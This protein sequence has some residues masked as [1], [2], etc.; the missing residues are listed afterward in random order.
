MQGFVGFA[1]FDELLGKT[2][3]GEQPVFARSAIGSQDGPGLQRA[4]NRF[5]G[6][7]FRLFAFAD[8][9]CAVDGDRHDIDLLLRSGSG[10][11]FPPFA[12]SC[13]RIGLP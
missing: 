11:G 4:Q 2:R 8:M 1:C 12:D 7:M 13:E 10:V 9:V 6:R 5:A 3:F